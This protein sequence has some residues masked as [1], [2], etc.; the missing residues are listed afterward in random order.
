MPTNKFFN[1]HHSPIGSFSSF[2]LGFKGASGGFDLELGKPPRQ[3]V[4][5]GLERKDGGGYDTLPFHEQGGDDESKRSAG[6][7]PDPNPDKPQIL[8]HYADDE[9]TRD[10][11]LATDSWQAG[12]L[13]FRILS[14]VRPVPDPE[15]APGAELKEVLL[16]AVL[17]ELEID[18]TSG[19]SVRRAFFGFQGNDPYN[20]LRR[21]DG[22]PEELTGVGQGR[23]LA[24][25]AEQ[26]SVKA[27]MHFTMEDILTTELEENW[28]FGLG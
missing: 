12:D 27:A 4:Y 6:G 22:G 17:V 9:I 20:A 16:P 11:R 1:A 13:T 28:T 5:I 10:F 8:H 25:A 14:P 3:N 7:N 18:N 15:S 19:G 2:T 24:I 23:F 26:G 21:F